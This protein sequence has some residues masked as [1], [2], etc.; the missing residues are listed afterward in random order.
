[1]R[2]LLDTSSSIN[3]SSTKRRGLSSLESASSTS[4][5]SSYTTP[6]TRK[7]LSYTIRSASTS[8]SASSTTSSTRKRPSSDSKS[9]L[10]PLSPPVPES[11]NLSPCRTLLNDCCWNCI[12]VTDKVCPNAKAGHC[13]GRLVGAQWIC[14]VIFLSL[15]Y[16]VSLL[17]I[18]MNLRI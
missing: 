6:S 11:L 2:E 14:T 7:R 1:V 18:R 17:L 15:S 4:S 12:F 16:S 8:S 13:Q 10:S 5:N 9:S 3:P